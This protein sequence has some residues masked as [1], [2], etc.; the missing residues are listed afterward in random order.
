MINEKIDKC[1]MCGKNKGSLIYVCKVCE[2]IAQEKIF[3]YVTDWHDVVPDYIP[4]EQV[5]AY[6]KNY[7][8]KCYEKNKTR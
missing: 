4:N 1:I 3:N 7:V 5:Q 2:N 8:I 6:V